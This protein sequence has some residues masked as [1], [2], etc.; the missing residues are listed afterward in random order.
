MKVIMIDDQQNVKIVSNISPEFDM[1][2]TDHIIPCV[3]CGDPVLFEFATDLECLKCHKPSREAITELGWV[4]EHPGY[5]EKNFGDRITVIAGTG[6][7]RFDISMGS[8]AYDCCYECDISIEVGDWRE[9]FAQLKERGCFGPEELEELHKVYE[10]LYADMMKNK[11]YTSGN[12]AAD[13]GSMLEPDGMY[14]LNNE[15][16]TEPLHITKRHLFGEHVKELTEQQN[17]QFA[18]LQSL[19]MTWLCNTIR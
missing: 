15:T 5:F 9:G 6:E 13:Y 10:Y 3:M 14:C 12:W 4:W 1:A 2:I 16:E 7:Y 8:A 11:I 19:I 17:T 18:E